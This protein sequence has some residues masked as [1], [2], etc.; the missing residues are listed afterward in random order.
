M[1]LSLKFE[2]TNPQH[3]QK[4]R[5]KKKDS[6]KIVRKISVPCEFLRFWD[7]CKIAEKTASRSSS[8]SNCSFQSHLSPMLPSFPHCFTKPLFLQEEYHTSTSWNVNIYRFELMKNIQKHFLDQNLKVSLFYFFLCAL[9]ELLL[10]DIQ[11][12]LLN[13]VKLDFS[14]NV[15]SLQSE[16]IC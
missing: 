8:K 4:P 11:E 2:T 9:Y 13:S 5:V 15:K 14:S 12:K 16:N 10:E 6:I 3:P 1:R 7:Q